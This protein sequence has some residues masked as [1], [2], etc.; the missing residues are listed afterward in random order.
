[1]GALQVDALPNR[2]R[3]SGDPAINAFLS[4]EG[5][6]QAAVAAAQEVQVGGR[7][8]VAGAGPS[9]P[10]WALPPAASRSMRHRFRKRGACPPPLHARQAKEAAREEAKAERRARAEAALAAE[11][12]AGAGQHTSEFYSFVDRGAGSEAGVV[13]AARRYQERLAGAEAAL[14]RR[15]AVR[16][17]LQAQGLPTY[18]ASLL[19]A[20]EYYIETGAGS[21]G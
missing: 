11:G 5:E 18:Y 8:G 15:A 9:G 19:S 12:L 14:Q 6:L 16:A 7:A 21:G 10:A 2:L 3:Y 17:L 1:M 20:I 13:A 4:G